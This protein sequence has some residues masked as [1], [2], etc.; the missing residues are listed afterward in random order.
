MPQKEREKRMERHKVGG[1]KGWGTE[2]RE[3]EEEEKN[4]RNKLG[5]VHLIAQGCH[6]LQPA[7]HAGRGITFVKVEQT[8]KMSNLFGK[9]MVCSRCSTGIG[10]VST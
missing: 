1:G 6:F 10:G 4:R 7:L 5:K 2:R 3:Q 9:K 8:L